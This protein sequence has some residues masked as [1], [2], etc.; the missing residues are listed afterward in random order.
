L[1]CKIL[2]KNKPG[3]WLHLN[4]SVL[5]S[6]NSRYWTS[7]DIIQEEYMYILLFPHF[8]WH[9]TGEIHVH[10][11]VST[12]LLTLYRRNTCTCSCFHTSSDIIQEEYMYIL[13]FPHFFWHYTGGIHVH[14]PVSTLLLTLYRRNTCTCSCFHTSSD[15][16]QEEY[17]YMLLFPHFFWH[18]TG[19]IHVHTPVSTHLLTYRRNTCTYSC[20]HT[21]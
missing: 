17:M 5:W 7:S 3:E 6:Q 14:T 21:W 8:F 9:Y 12:L 18:Y 1:T 10:A 15:I 19:G 20:F 4:Y 16:I 2:N 11:P 13:L